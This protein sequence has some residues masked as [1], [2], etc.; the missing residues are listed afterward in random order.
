MDR[1]E[2]QVEQQALVEVNAMEVVGR[3]RSTTGRRLRRGLRFVSLSSLLS[4][5]GLLD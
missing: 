4:Y 5:T 2:L 3:A 1:L